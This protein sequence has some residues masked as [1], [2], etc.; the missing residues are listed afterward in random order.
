[1]A[2]QASMERDFREVEGRMEQGFRETE[3]GFREMDNKIAA[4]ERRMLWAALGLAVGIG[5]N[6]IVS[7]ATIIVTLLT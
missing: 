1:M 3:R 6:I 2:T 4:V 5:V 7:L